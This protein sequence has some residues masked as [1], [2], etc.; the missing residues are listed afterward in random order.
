[1]LVVSGISRSLLRVIVT[2]G[3]ALAHGMVV[4]HLRK[5][6]AEKG[7]PINPDTNYVEDDPLQSWVSNQVK[8]SALGTE[9]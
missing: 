4:M 2:M 1:M 9:I 6:F 8:D 3:L 7:W 5:K